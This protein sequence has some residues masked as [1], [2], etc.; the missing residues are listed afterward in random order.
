MFS[1]SLLHSTHFS[2]HFTQFRGC[3][4]PLSWPLLRKLPSLSFLHF[5]RDPS[6]WLDSAESVIKPDQFQFSSLNTPPTA[7]IFQ[8]TGFCCLVFRPNWCRTHLTITTQSQGKGVVS[9]L[10]SSFLKLLLLGWWWVTETFEESLRSSWHVIVLTA[11]PALSVVSTAAP[12]ALSSEQ[13]ITADSLRPNDCRHLAGARCDGASHARRHVIPG[14]HYWPC[15][16]PVQ[17]PR[18]L[19]F[20]QIATFTQKTQNIS[21]CQYI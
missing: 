10:I 6:F 17:T 3:T 12:W 16:H 1:G 14:S 20:M 7:S 13:L 21:L 8:K 2:V 5:G 19:L 15:H 11:A 9:Q 4:A 18:K